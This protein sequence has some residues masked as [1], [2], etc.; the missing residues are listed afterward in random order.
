[1]SANSSRRF[2]AIIGAILLLPACGS[3][4]T[5]GAGSEGD[6]GS[7]A[8]ACDA[9]SKRCDGATIKKCDDT[10]THESV[11]R[12]C[13][14]GQ[15]CRSDGGEV[16]CN[17]VACA[18][19]EP[20]CDGSIAT[21][22]KTDG[23][24]PKPGGIDCA[25][26]GETCTDGECHV[27]TCKRGQKFCHDEDVYLCELDGRTSSPLV[28]CQAG[29]ACDPELAACRPKICEPGMST[30]DGTVIRTCD[31]SGT[32]FFP[33]S[34][35][36]A[37]DGKMCVAGSCGT[38]V[39]EPIQRSC[40]DGD[41]Y[42]CDAEGSAMTLS[43]R[44]DRETEHCEALGGGYAFC[45]PNECAPGEKRCVGN[46][47]KTCNDEHVLPAQG[48][49]CGDEAWCEHGECKPRSCTPGTLFCDRSDVYYCEE[50]AAP[51][52]QADCPSETACR[53]V[54]PD[55]AP[56]SFSGASCAPLTCTPGSSACLQ[57][58]LGTCGADGESLSK[59]S[60]DCAANGDVCTAEGECATSATDV[61]GIDE[62]AELL[63]QGTFF[64]N[65]LE[66]RSTRKLSELR[67]WLVFS[68]QRQLRWLVYEQSGSSFVPKVDKLVTV[69]SSTG[70]VS[71]G[72]GS[73]SYQLQ[74]GKRYAIGVVVSGDAVSAYDS[75]P[76]AG[77]PSFGTLLGRMVGTYPGAFTANESFMADVIVHMQVVT[78]LAP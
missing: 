74:A 35:D 30:C 56:F 47:V 54:F 70:V 64:G 72:A 75:A 4:S 20:V 63:Y 2:G 55:A 68:S 76:F 57:N 27:P 36:C 52:L 48:T 78:S 25:D 40:Q 15:S 71:S 73:F 62:N 51:S 11:E 43:Q 14:S 45:S 29:E 9:G 33:N 66:V 69:P 12:T 1:M 21:S 50:M 67:M 32:H 37:E 39:C 42:Q 46:V 28:T 26:A 53:V 5:N 49:D 31:A 10:G 34:F 60:S 61:L 18:P 77:N 22:C 17:A 13:P 16:A 65:L 41:V 59:M 7:G 24:G 8:T 6:G 23:S 3:S 38:P 19:N 58:Q 44:C